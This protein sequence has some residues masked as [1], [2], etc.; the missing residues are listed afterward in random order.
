MTV[1]NLR[2]FLDLLRKEG[3]LVE[4]EAPVDPYLE[5]AEIHRRVIAAYEDVLS[6]NGGLVQID[7]SG[8]AEEIAARVRDA[9]GL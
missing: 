3:D 5:I 8:D 7:G 4:I 6:Q 1:R 2:I 9:L